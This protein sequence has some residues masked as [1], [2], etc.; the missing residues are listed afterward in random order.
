[1]TGLGLPRCRDVAGALVS[2]ALLA[3][4]ANAG[5]STTVQVAKPAGAAPIIEAGKFPHALL[6]QALKKHV[7]DAGRVDYKALRAD[8][9]DLERYLYA[10]SKVSPKSDPSKFGS[11]DEAL[12]YWIN[13]YNAYTIYAV[14]ER[15]AMRSVIDA[16][17]NFFYFTEYV[18]GGESMSLYSLEN[19]IVRP[20]FKEPLVHMALNCASVGCP[21]LPAEAFLP[22]TL[23]AQLANEATEFCAHPDKVRVKAGKVE[24]SQIFE[25]YRDDFE[26][27]GGPVG[28][29]R[30]WGRDDLPDGDLSYI[31]Y[32]WSLNAQP[33]T[34]LFE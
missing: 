30:K 32:D 6:D 14:T 4:C 23:Q 22:A 12:A 31:P 17:T 7:D 10:V 28:F 2:A 29:C 5:C 3:A 26:A 33:G 27:D 34:A 25:F 24:V 1:M 13:A 20:E 16:K 21:E 15:P 9:A 18:L 11:R 19:D 8:R